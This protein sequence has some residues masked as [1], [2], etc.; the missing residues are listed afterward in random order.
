MSCGVHHLEKSCAIY[1]YSIYVVLKVTTIMKCIKNWGCVNRKHF[2]RGISKRWYMWLVHSPE[3]FIYSDSP[4]ILLVLTI[5]IIKS[6][7]WLLVET[8]IKHF[9]RI[10]V[11]VYSQKAYVEKKREKSSDVNEMRRTMRGLKEEKWSAMLNDKA[12]DHYANWFEFVNLCPSHWHIDNKIDIWAFKISPIH[13]KNQ[14]ITDG[15][16]KNIHKNIIRGESS[17]KE[18]TTSPSCKT[19][20]TEPNPPKNPILHASTDIA[21]IYCVYHFLPILAKLSAHPAFIN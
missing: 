8:W 19:T 16:K 9:V 2:H 13:T 20:L 18:N 10:K 6:T 5:W 7:I 11:A 4:L 3:K 15:A 1:K 14:A 21:I 17:I 12:N